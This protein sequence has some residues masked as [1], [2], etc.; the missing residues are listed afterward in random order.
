ML[1]VL[2]TIRAS[3]G[4]GHKAEWDDRHPK[5]G[6]PPCERQVGRVNPRRD[7]AILVV[8]GNTVLLISV[9]RGKSVL[10]SGGILQTQI[11][12]QE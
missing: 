8:S 9:F 2:D 12:K 3:F 5:Q 7:E 1:V 11:P 4:H 6:T 10:I